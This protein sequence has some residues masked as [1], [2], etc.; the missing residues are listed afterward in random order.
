VD[1]QRK[2]GEEHFRGIH[3]VVESNLDD[4]FGDTFVPKF[5]KIVKEE[6]T[7]LWNPICMT[8]WRFFYYKVIQDCEG[9]IHKVVESNLDDEFLYHSIFSSFTADIELKII[10]E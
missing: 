6:F 2:E 5:S 1:I 4:F 10:R 7:K 8:F 3:K 9:R